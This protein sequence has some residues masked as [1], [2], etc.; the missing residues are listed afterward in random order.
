M[1]PLLAMV[2]A[3]LPYETWFPGTSKIDEV[4]A[5]PAAYRGVWGT[6][7]A[8]CKAEFGIDRI[9]VKHGGINYWEAGARLERVTQAGQERTIK[10]KLSYEGEGTFWDRTETWLLNEDGTSLTMTAEGGD[11]PMTFVKC[12]R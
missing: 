2:L 12:K 4:E 3:E 9:E 11:G 10:L 1:L 5:I 8:A 7:V 6:N